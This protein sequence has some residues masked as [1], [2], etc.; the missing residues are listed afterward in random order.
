MFVKAHHVAGDEDATA[1]P[2]KGRVAPTMVAREGTMVLKINIHPS[3]GD[4]KRART[5]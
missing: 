2:W 3:V 1:D 4:S 5:E